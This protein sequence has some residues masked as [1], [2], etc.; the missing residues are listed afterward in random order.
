MESSIRVLHLGLCPNRGGI[1]TIVHSWWEHIDRQRVHFDFVNVYHE[2]IAFEDE[3]KEY[4]SE[5]YRIPARKENFGKHKEELK[6]II[7]NG[8]Y[9]FVHCHVMSLSEPEPVMIC[10]ELGLKTQPIIHSHTVAKLSTMSAKRKIL[11]FYGSIRLKGHK[12][13]RVACGQEAGKELFHSH[14]FTVIENG[15]DVN[16]YKFSKE[17]RRRFRNLY[18]IGEETFVIGHIGRLDKAKNYPFLIETIAEVKKRRK[19]AILVLVGDL[20]GSEMINTLLD[21]YGVKDSCILTGKLSST[22]DAYSGFDVFFFPS[23]YEGISVSMIEAQASGLLCVVSENIA[24][25]SA[26]SDY[27]HFMP[28]TDAQ[29]MAEAIVKYADKDNGTRE[30]RKIIQEYDIRK[31]SAKLQEYYK[32]NIHRRG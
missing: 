17:K 1:E 28:I 10:E 15:I 24:H 29:K 25:E 9:D 32:M 26:V 22:I 30:E 31:S 18:G 5:V 13:L 23:K 19:D 14:D 12:Y 4:D 6:N 16:D 21:K 7:R 3:F 8:N 2:P 27:V 11:H 20:Q